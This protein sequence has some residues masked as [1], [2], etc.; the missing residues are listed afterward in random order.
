[1]EATMK[2]PS[3]Y[4]YGRPPPGWNKRTIEKY[5]MEGKLF[6]SPVEILDII[7]LYHGKYSLFL[8]VKK[9]N[10][11]IRR[12]RALISLIILSCARLNEALKVR[13]S[14]VDLRDPDWAFIR[15]FQVSKRKKGRKEFIATLPITRQEDATLY[16]FTELFLEHYSEIGERSPLFKI[17]TRRARQI[18]TAI[19]PE[20]FPHYLRSCALTYYLN[21]LKNPLAVAKIFGVK[22]VGTLS[23]YYSATWEAFKEELAQ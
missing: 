16:P 11:L 17:G 2:E 6:F 1:M 15:N 18:I 22:S 10:Q 3:K 12:D 8:D 23:R 7:K 19:H 20:I 9:V 4:G 13:R 5:F 21:A 14:Q